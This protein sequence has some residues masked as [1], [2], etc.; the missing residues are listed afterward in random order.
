MGKAHMSAWGSFKVYVKY[1]CVSEDYSL[2]TP[3]KMYPLEGEP[4]VFCDF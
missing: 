4:L 3:L 1:V 2:L